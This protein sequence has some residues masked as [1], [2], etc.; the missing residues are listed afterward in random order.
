VT[1]L[2]ELASFYVRIV[3]VYWS[4][5]PTLLLLAAIVFLPLGLIGAVATEIDVE[6]IDLD[7]AIKVAALI[8]AIGA[9]TATSLLGEVF[10]SGAIAIGL[11]HPEHEHPPKLREIARRINYRRLIVIDILYVALV[12]LG[13][14]AFIIPGVL[15]FVYLGLAG[16]VVEIEERTVRQAFRR[17]FELVHGRFWFVFLV[18]API[19]ILGDAVGEYLGHAIH[20]LFADSFLGTWLAESASSSV[21]SPLFAVAVVLLTLD[22]IERKD[23]SAPTLKRKPA[24]IPPVPA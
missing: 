7:S 20:E 14:V 4:W 2:R 16:P 1:F 23:G 13:M 5:A 19:E 11:T 8:G 6:S 10:Y 24:P 18:L 17:S 3:R 15:I 21:L 12:L 22:L 9:V